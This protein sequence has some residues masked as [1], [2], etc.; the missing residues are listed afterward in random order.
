M[1]VVCRTITP[2]RSFVVFLAQHGV[3]TWA[4]WSSMGEDGWGG[5]RQGR[6]PTK[7]LQAFPMAHHPTAGGDCPWQRYPG[8]RRGLRLS[9]HGAAWGL[10]SPGLGTPMSSQCHP[11]DPAHHHDTSGTAQHSQ[12]CNKQVFPALHC[13]TEATDNDKFSSCCTPEN[14]HVQ[15]PSSR[16]HGMLCRGRLTAFWGP[17][18]WLLQPY[19]RPALRQNGQGSSIYHA[20]VWRLSLPSGL[21]CS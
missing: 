12:H 3:D 2:H 9:W 13:L 10:E 19:G 16:H 7:S 6:N 5:A 15:F 14:L 4:C 17:M 8:L 11:T 1:M 21:H 20:D 18:M